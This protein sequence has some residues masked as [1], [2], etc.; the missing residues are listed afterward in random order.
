[1]KNQNK[2]MMLI[3]GDISG[4]VKDNSESLFSEPLLYSLNL[5]ET[6]PYPA[7]AL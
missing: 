2:Q 1:M 6:V 3:C 7:P 4:D 5:L